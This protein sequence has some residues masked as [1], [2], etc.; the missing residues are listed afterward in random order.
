[1]C[2]Y[3][4]IMNSYLKMIQKQILKTGPAATLNTILMVE[5][6]LKNT[7]ESVLTVAEMKRKL[8]KQVN[9]TTLMRI[10]QY[11]EES[12]KIFVS[13]KGI[14]WVA[15]ENPLLKKAIHAGKRY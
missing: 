10:L 4:L 13:L 1:M 3:L 9:H 8:P 5:T 15:E 12:N 14:T 11:L 6:L 2:P 7:K